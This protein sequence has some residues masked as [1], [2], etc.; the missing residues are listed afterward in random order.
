MSF[1]YFYFSPFPQVSVLCK[2]HLSSP[3]PPLT[4]PKAVLIDIH[5]LWGHSLESHR[6][7][8]KSGQCL[9]ITHKE[10][11]LVWQGPGHRSP[12]DLVVAV[13][14][15]G[16]CLT[17]CHPMA[18]SMARFLVVHY[19]PESSKPD[20]PWA[21]QWADWPGRL[22]RCPSEIGEGKHLPL[23]PLQYGPPHPSYLCAGVASFPG[24]WYSE[25]RAS[26]QVTGLS[27]SL[28]L[29]FS[30]ARTRRLAVLGVG[31][32][33]V[34]GRPETPQLPL[35]GHTRA[36]PSWALKLL[37]FLRLSFQW[38]NTLLLSL[39]S[40]P[41]TLPSSLCVI[42]Y[43][44]PSLSPKSTI[45]K[46]KQTKAS[47]TWNIRALFPHLAVES[48]RFSFGKYFT[49]EQCIFLSSIED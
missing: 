19:L 39:P 46:A 20:Y 12:P 10:V 6:T 11:E 9:T 18:C 4:P 45:W 40:Q 15:R 7:I 42:S 1:S 27:L 35:P 32:G 43:Q 29:S 36:L 5:N 22:G 34:Q 38:F 26:L 16:R 2:L 17:L 33:G 48:E 23:F 14:S 24:G 28:S 21:L 3:P 13:Q 47:L 49:L 37:G 8:C 44:L 41:A 25:V 31:R 30:P